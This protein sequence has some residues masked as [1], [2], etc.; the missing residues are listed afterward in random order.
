MQNV[1][2]L[3]TPKWTQVGEDWQ[4]LVR[5]KSVALLIPVSEE[6]FPHIHWVSVLYYYDDLDWHTVDFETLESAMCDTEQWWLD[7][8]R[9]L[10][11]PRPPKPVR[12]RN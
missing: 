10:R 11:P 9:G 12:L 1:D 8:C 6:K 5:N 4:L 3:H 2:L 7:M